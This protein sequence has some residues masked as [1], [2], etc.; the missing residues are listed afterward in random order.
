MSEGTKSKRFQRLSAKMRLQ[1]YMETRPK[2]APVGE[3]LRRYGLT[4]EDLRDIE[5]V[6]E[7]ALLSAFKVHFGRRKAPESVSPEEHARIVEELKEKERALSDLSV[8]YTLLKKKERLDLKE[9][10]AE[11]GSRRRRESS[12][13]KSSRRRR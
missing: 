5:R 13:S 11:S 6:A 4:L 3:I 1:I 8:E 10:E 12:S 2:D 7:S 9:E